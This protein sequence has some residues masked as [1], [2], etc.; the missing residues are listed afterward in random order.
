MIDVKLNKQ[1]S[2]SAHRTTNYESRI[3]AT[4]ILFI[5]FLSILPCKS[6]RL[7]SQYNQ[8]CQFNSLHW[9]DKNTSHLKLG[10]LKFRIVRL[11]VR[12]AEWDKFF[13]QIRLVCTLWGARCRSAFVAS[14]TTSKSAAYITM[15]SNILGI[16][17][18]QS[19]AY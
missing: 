16:D 19:C 7:I 5:Y 2:R 12:W 4:N 17:I 11:A 14:T 10:K 13:E 8:K 3:F 15:D 18:L 9:K 6:F 1:L